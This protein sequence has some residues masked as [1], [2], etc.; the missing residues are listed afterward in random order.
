MEGENQGVKG[1]KHK[2]RLL[3][4]PVRRFFLLARHRDMGPVDILSGY[5]YQA[6]PDLSGRRDPSHSRLDAVRSVKFGADEQSAARHVG[7]GPQALARAA[8]TKVILGYLD[9]TEYLF[10]EVLPGPK[11]QQDSSLSIV[12][13]N[14]A[15]HKSWARFAQHLNEQ[16]CS[17]NSFPLSAV[18]TALSLPDEVNPLPARFLCGSLQ[19][20]YSAYSEGLLLLGL[21]AP[22]S[23]TSLELS[24]V[25]DS[26]IMSKPALQNFLDQ[27]C[28]TLAHILA[29]LAA[30]PYS[31]VPLPRNL[32]SSYEEEYD[33]S[34]AHVAVDW[35]THNAA[36]RPNAIAH[37]IYATLDE[38]P[39]VLTFAELNA[40]SNRLAR[41]FLNH[42][43]QLED[44]V[45][46]CRPRD[47]HFY[48][49]NAA[50]FK[51]G[52]CYVSVCRSTV[53]PE[54]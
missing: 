42:G 1:I 31:T 28:A 37:E 26:S 4:F 12:R 2:R 3:V 36:T 20:L 35:L 47:R 41:W 18:R 23:D 30:S 46:V 32:I 11:E 48:V 15:E 33:S 39:V 16:P 52:A 51:S 40:Q 8:F 38:S 50:L 9:S 7:L 54:A 5:R 13:S 6:L 25:C 22:T 10:G 49:A 44:K 14:L 24:V 34:R 43:V 53:V 29:D 21:P 45:A 19:D 27:V 17:N